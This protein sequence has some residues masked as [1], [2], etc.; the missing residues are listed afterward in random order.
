M[1]K[2]TELC[3]CFVVERETVDRIQT[4][5]RTQQFVLCLHGH[6]QMTL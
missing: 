3:V 4:L 1:I 5:Q 6:D 2:L